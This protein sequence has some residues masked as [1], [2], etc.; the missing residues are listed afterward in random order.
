MEPTSKLPHVGTTIFTVM[1]A[2]AQEY[3][4]INLSQGFPDFSP[5]GT[6]LE[7]CAKAMKNGPHQYGPMPGHPMLRK[8]I[9]ET[10]KEK[11]GYSLNH[12]TEI[13]VTAGA[14]QAIFTAISAFVHPGDEVLYF[15][16]AY[17]C[18]EPAITL[19]GGIPIPIALS[20]NDFTPDWDKVAQ[21]VNEKTRM[22]II[23]NPHNPCSSILDEFHMRKL[24]AILEKHENL[25]VLSDEVY[26]H[27]CFHPKGHQ[28]IW[29]YKHLSERGIQ[30][31]SFGKTLHATGWKIGY[32]A[33]KENL[34]KEFRKV[35]QFNVFCVNHPL[36]D[37]LAHYLEKT[38]DFHK[39]SDMYIKK[40]DYFL[41][42]MK[43]T[44][45]RFHE[46]LGS[47]FILADY[48]E[49][50]DEPDTEFCKRLTIEFGVAA[51]PLSVFYHDK[52]DLKKI[53]FC[54][55]KKEDTLMH[56]AERL[57]KITS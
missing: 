52:R 51:I 35:H 20:D 28:S 53:R 11:Y 2:L 1:S 34:M 50:S 23:N 5:D 6:L 8:K 9:S 41:S 36:Q 27:I 19:N 46:C 17:D 31:C 42:L 22:I 39:I 54:F 43:H 12:D 13:T 38:P 18:Y 4:A 14:T 10:I 21:T 7:L 55:A 56:A 15:V 57:M 30:V 40:R 25:V 49:I 47:Y 26:E 44:S 37:A 32:C 16:P 3:N 29:K 24:D 33:A 48:S 45:F